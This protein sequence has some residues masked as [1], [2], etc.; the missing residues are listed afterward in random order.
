MKNGKK[1]NRSQQKI[2]REWSLNPEDWFI[3]KHTPAA[4]Y[5]IHRFSDKTTKV[6]HL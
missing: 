2:I 5:L 3:S 4:M 1:P 6:L